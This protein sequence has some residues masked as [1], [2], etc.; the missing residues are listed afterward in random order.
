MA[1]LKIYCKSLQSGF[2]LVYKQMYPLLRHCLERDIEFITFAWKWQER[3]MD[4][5]LNDVG[6]IDNAE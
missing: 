3:G 1:I 2:V 4:F 5:I 6:F